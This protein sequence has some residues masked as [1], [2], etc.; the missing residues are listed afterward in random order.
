MS[1]HDIGTLEEATPWCDWTSAQ[2]AEYQRRLSA[3]ETRLEALE[4]LAAT[5]SEL[6]LTSLHLP[7]SIAI[8]APGHHSGTMSFGMGIEGGGP[9]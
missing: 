9:R 8:V 2:E 4:L 7:Y 3:I 6:A 1:H 5:P